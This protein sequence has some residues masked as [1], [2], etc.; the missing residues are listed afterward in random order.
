MAAQRLEISALNRLEEIARVNETFNAFA[1]ERGVPDEVRRKLNLVFDELL[2]NII[3]YAYNDDDEHYIEIVFVIGDECFVVTI[4]DD[5]HPFNPLDSDDPN[6][7]LSVEDRP[8][9][10]LGLHLVRSVMDEVAYERHDKN[11]VVTLKK[12]PLSERERR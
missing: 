10:G 7:E 2:N 4:T 12:N 1:G 11:N 6:T 8:V 3:S 5:G 9:G